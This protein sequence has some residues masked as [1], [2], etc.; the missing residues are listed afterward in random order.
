[1]ALIPATECTVGSGPPVEIVVPDRDP[2]D[3]TAGLLRRIEEIAGCRF[4]LGPG[5]DTP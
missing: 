5:T 3:V 1:M 4:R 2:G